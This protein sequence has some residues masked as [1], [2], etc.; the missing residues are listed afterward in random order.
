MAAIDETSEAELRQLGDDQRIV[1]ETES[2]SI[3]SLPPVDGGA[4]AWLFLIGCFFIE[5]FLWG[6]IK[7]A[8]SYAVCLSH[9]LGFPFSFG[10]LR[11]YYSTHL[12]ISRY[13]SGVSAIGTTCSVW[14]L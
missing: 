10:V 14:I 13:A 3:P 2:Q 12:P 5:M 11:D 8:S 9:L 4:A 7:F 1:N 6:K